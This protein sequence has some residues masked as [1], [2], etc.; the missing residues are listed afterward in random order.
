MKHPT[1]SSS[2]S[3]PRFTL[4]ELLVVVAIIAILASLLLPALSRARNMAQRSSCANNAKQ[5]TFG[6]LM[7]ADEYDGILPSYQHY[8]EGLREYTSQI[9]GG[10]DG[11][12]STT[13]W[14]DRIYEFVNSVEV[15]RCGSTNQRWGG[16]AWNWHGAGYGML[17]SD[18]SGPLY[19]GIR[20]RRIEKPTEIPMLADTYPGSNNTLGAHQNW[21]TDGIDWPKYNPVRHGGGGNVAFIDGHVQWY[22]LNDQGSLLYEWDD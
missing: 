13:F 1:W 9:M 19:E 12:Q 16:Y 5:L 7:Y 14:V 8:Y 2:A 10:N 15:Y 22:S 17:R 4:I 20:L 6:S 21:D 11:V 18:R 3:A